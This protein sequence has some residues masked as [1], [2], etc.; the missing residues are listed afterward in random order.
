SGGSDTPSSV[1]LYAPDGT[2]LLDDLRGCDSSALEGWLKYY[3]PGS[4]GTSGVRTN[5]PDRFLFNVLNWPILSS[6]FPMYVQASGPVLW[7]DLIIPSRDFG[8]LVEPYFDRMQFREDIAERP[9]IA[10]SVCLTYSD[11]SFLI[12]LYERQD[13]FL[14]QRGSTWGCYSVPSGFYNA[15]VKYVCT[16]GVPHVSFTDEEIQAAEQAA[17]EYFSAEAPAR[18]LNALWYDDARCQWMRLTYLKNGRGAENGV[19]PQNVLVLL[20]DFTIDGEEHPDWSLI[21]I[22]DSAQAAWR[23][24][25]QGY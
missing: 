10:P 19:N 2:L 20:C 12:L 11:T 5:E 15:I 14:V 4:V 3:L 1:A 23:L 24:D 16:S 13:F 17:R 21:F 9:Q 25:D 18:E 22:R 8:S 7:D 6:Q